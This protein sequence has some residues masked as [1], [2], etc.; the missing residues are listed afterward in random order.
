MLG[1]AMKSF[2]ALQHGASF[3]AQRPAMLPAR[4]FAFKTSAVPWRGQCAGKS[5]QFSRITASLEP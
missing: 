1:G 2:S 5:L 4:L 3:G